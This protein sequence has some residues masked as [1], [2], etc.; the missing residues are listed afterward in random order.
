MLAEAERV[1]FLPPCDPLTMASTRPLAKEKAALRA[2]FRS[3][4]TP[5]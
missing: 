4:S 5:S 1:R 3:G 2:G